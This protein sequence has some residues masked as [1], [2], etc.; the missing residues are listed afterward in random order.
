[1]SRHPLE[2]QSKTGRG[3]VSRQL[4]NRQENLIS[5]HTCLLADEGSGRM[6]ARL[7]PRIFCG[8]CVIV[9]VIV[10]SKQGA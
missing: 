9:H 10:M 8:A 3:N 6:H 7:T 2:E 1:M 5:Y 4:V